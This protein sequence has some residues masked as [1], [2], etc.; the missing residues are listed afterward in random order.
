MAKHEAPKPPKSSIYPDPLIIPPLE[1]HKATWIILHGRGSNAHKFGPEL[2]A[3]KIPVYGSLPQ[4]FPHAKF[5]FPTASIRRATIYKRSPIN[6]WFD[7]WSLQTPTEREELQIDGLRETSAFI[8][9]LLRKE[10]ARVGAK[11]VVIGG[12]SQGCAGSLISTLL[13]EGEP[14]AAV[15]GMCGW[16]PFRQH[17]QDIAKGVGSGE[18]IECDTDDPFEQDGEFLS[19]WSTIFLTLASS[20]QRVDAAQLS[21]VKQAI[22][23]LRDELELPNL[24]ESLAFQHTPVFLGHGTEDEKVPVELGREAASC[25]DALGGIVRWEEYEGLG[26]WYS[27]DMLADVIK[28]V[29]EKQHSAH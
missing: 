8:H 4:A 11:N 20:D 5:I 12:L 22:R 6:Q 23:Y 2:L 14:L 7:N 26:H 19:C 1:E 3:M 29:Q 18:D 16:L 10:I 13:W 21:P 24:E 17:M 15:F 28:F 25:F 9:D 27:A